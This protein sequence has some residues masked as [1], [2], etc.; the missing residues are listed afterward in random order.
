M[1]DLGL[2]LA[3]ATE[4]CAETRNLI[5]DVIVGVQNH[6]YMSDIVKQALLSKQLKGMGFS[7]EQLR[8]FS[9]GK[10]PT[11]Y[12]LVPCD[13]CV[14]RMYRVWARVPTSIHNNDDVRKIAKKQILDN[15]L[16]ERDLV[17]DFDIEE[18]DIGGIDID[19]C[20]AQLE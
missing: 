13:V 7:D 5:E 8:A 6:C 2:Y 10:I 15:G 3:R 12:K 18:D 17:L 19:W 20:G 16:N 9:K 4:Y 11:E 14:T 1:S